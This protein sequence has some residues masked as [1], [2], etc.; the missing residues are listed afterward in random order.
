MNKTTFSFQTELLRTS[1]RYNKQQKVFKSLGILA[2]YWQLCQEMKKGNR[3]QT[4]PGVMFGK[5]FSYFAQL[6]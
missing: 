5:A 3:V 4:I 2:K 6:S 1:G